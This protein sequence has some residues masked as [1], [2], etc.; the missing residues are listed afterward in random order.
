[1]TLTETLLPKLKE[2]G[3]S[4]E[5]IRIIVVENPHRFFDGG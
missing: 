5:A 1:L 4:D 2:S 3:A